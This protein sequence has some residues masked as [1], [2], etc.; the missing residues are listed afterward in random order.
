MNRFAKIVSGT[1]Q[2]V[3]GSE[4]EY[5]DRR[6]D[7]GELI[8]RRVV[9]HIPEYDVETQMLGNAFLQISDEVVIETYEVIPLL[10]MPTIHERLDALECGDIERIQRHQRIIQGLKNAGKA[11]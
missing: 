10:D 4:L 3:A 11:P 5:D 9:T 2:A 6:D 8:W 1:V 7:S